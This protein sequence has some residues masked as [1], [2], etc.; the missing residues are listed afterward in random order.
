MSRHVPDKMYAGMII[1]YKVSPLFN[2]KM[3][4]GDGDHPRD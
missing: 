2:I 3:D 4:W 1:T